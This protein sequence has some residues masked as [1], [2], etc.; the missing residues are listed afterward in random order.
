MSEIILTKAIL[1]SLRTPSGGFNRK[2]LTLLGV[3]WPPT[4]KWK[5]KLVGTSIDSSLLALA[6]SS[7]YTIPNE[8]YGIPHK[9]APV[10]Y[11]DHDTHFEIQSFIYSS[12]KNNFDIR[13]QIYS[14]FT[15]F[16][17]VI[18]E[19]KE[20]VMIINILRE[21]E[22]SESHKLPIR[23]ITTMAEAKKLV[24]EFMTKK[25]GLN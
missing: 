25:L 1:E 23:I 9:D 12:L 17:L 8:P 5:R 7:A 22:A 4:K 3:G 18:F 20:P 19:N 6:G 10:T 2:T 21:G 11:P 15:T 14:G 13:G 16:D 24:T